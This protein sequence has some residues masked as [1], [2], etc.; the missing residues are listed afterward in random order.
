MPYFVKIVLRM[1]NDI[2]LLLT[3][4]RNAYYKTNYLLYTTRHFT[5]LQDVWENYKVA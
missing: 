3:R 4:V 1:Y 5:V 2:P